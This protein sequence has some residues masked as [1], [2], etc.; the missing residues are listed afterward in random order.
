MDPLAQ[1]SNKA[2]A[3]V[4]ST[5]Q[6][7]SLVGFV[8]ESVWVASAALPGWDWGGGGS[9]CSSGDNLRGGGGEWSS[10]GWH[11][12][13]GHDTSASEVSV[14]AESDGIGL[15]QVVEG[16][17]VEDVSEEVGIDFTVSDGASLF[18]GISPS[19]TVLCAG[20]QGRV[21]VGWVK[22]ERQTGDGIYVLDGDI[23]LGWWLGVFAVDP[24]AIFG[25]V[26]SFTVSVDKVH[27]WASSGFV[28]TEVAPASVLEDV[29]QSKEVHDVSVISSRP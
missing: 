10:G 15:V 2:V 18:F 16:H 19:T 23:A 20:A 28:V 21:V 17:V 26:P 14:E 1:H 5:Q 29:G 8:W 22:W 11:Q 3:K 13:V 6:S 9:W 12:T 24:D 25:I 4:V 27:G 7:S